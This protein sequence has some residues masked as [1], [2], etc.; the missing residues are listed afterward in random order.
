MRQAWIIALLFAVA[1]AIAQTAKPTTP[2]LSRPTTGPATDVV[3]SPDQL[4]RDERLGR[5][6][7]MF[8]WIRGHPNSPESKHLVGDILLFRAD[9]LPG[10]WAEFGSGSLAAVTGQNFGVDFDAW[11]RWYATV[12][13][14]PEWS[15]SPIPLPHRPAPRPPPKRLPFAIAYA[16][17]ATREKAMTWSLTGP[18]EFHGQEANFHVWSEKPL[19]LKLHDWDGNLDVE[20]DF[21]AGAGTV[22][23]ETRNGK[24]NLNGLELVVLD[25]EALRRIEQ[26]VDDRLLRQDDPQKVMDYIYGQGRLGNLLPMARWHLGSET[27][28]R[29]ATDP[30]AR[31]ELVRE[32]RLDP[33]A[34]AKMTA[35]EIAIER[36]RREDY[37]RVLQTNRITIR[38]IDATHAEWEA[39]GAREASSGR[40]ILG[41][42]GWAPDK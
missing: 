31:R 25:L 24:F 7:G 30:G 3:T 8:L 34:A 41:P 19:R 35:E 14:Q 1:P 11:D 5:L 37:A 4:D 23:V 29:E 42:G 20:G 2:P 36:C 22:T 38:R 12:R 13:D 17:R 28:R 18:C 27:G 33:D 16:T 15:P 40:L 26:R 6:E 39:D 9:L 10:Q 32:L 21:K